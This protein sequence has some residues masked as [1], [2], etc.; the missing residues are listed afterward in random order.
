MFTDPGQAPD[1]WALGAPFLP[2]ER[3][4]HHRPLPGL[5]S[6]CIRLAGQIPSALSVIQNTNVYLESLTNECL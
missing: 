2:Q 3:G 1:R 4:V 5:N 6:G